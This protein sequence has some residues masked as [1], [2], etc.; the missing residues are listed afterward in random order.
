MSFGRDAFRGTID[1]FAVAVGIV[2]CDFVHHYSILFIIVM[3]FSGISFSENF[4]CSLASWTK[5]MIAA[6]SSPFSSI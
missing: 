6:S 4:F 5:A 2:I 1:Q 3:M